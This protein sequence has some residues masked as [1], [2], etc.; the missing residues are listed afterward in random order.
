MRLRRTVLP[1]PDLLDIA[2]AF[3]SFGLFTLPVLIRGSGHSPTAAIVVLGLAATV[4]L[5]VRRR[6]PVP[7]LATVSLVLVGAALADVGFTVFHSNAGPALG[8]AVLTV[9]DR[10]PR[11][12]SLRASVAAVGLVTVAEVTAMQVHPATG[13]N[14]IQLVLAVPAWLV[15]YAF[16]TRRQAERRLR[17]ET[18]ERAREAERRVRAEERVRVSADV[19]D[20]VS[21]TLSMIA[22]R[23]GVARMVLEQRPEEALAALSAIETA[24]RGALDELRAVLQSLRDAPGDPLRT[25]GALAA[26][27]AVERPTL[28]HLRSLVGNLRDDGYPI[29][30]AL[31]EKAGAPPPVEESA[32]RVVQEALTNVV[33]HAGRVATSVEVAGDPEGLSI[34][35][36]NAAPAGGSPGA[37]PGSGHGLTGMRDRVA[38]YEGTVA[39]GPCPDGGYAVRVHF[40]ARPVNRTAPADR[41]EGKRRG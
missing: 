14:A 36:L 21:H 29:T 38:L 8:I 17:S 22:V 41:A 1:S 37:G 18:Q 31:S 27:P 19:H 28:A 24:S 40:P 33:R 10:L 11:A 16:H 5:S 26:G 23:S 32:Y 30:L 9:A 12:V 2:L 25:A 13:Q 4:P 6:A 7:V 34:S 35:V 20:I 15:G 3:G 39:A